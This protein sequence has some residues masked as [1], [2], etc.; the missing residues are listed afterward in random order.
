MVSSSTVRMDI[1]TPKN[2]ATVLSENVRVAI[3]QQCGI[4]S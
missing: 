1:L 4:I 3:T 2:E